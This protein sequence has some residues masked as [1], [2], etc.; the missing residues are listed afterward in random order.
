MKKYIKRFLPIVLAVSIMLCSMVLCANVVEFSSM[1]T[2]VASA[3]EYEADG[4]AYTD[5]RNGTCYINGFS[6]EEAATGVSELVIPETLNG[7]TV[8]GIQLGAFM[9]CTELKKVVIP[10]T[11]KVISHYVFR[12]C[13]NL[14]EIVLSKNLVSIGYDAFKSCEKLYNIEIPDSVTEISW[15]VF[16]NTAYYNDETNWEN[17]LLYLDN[18]L[19]SAKSDFSGELIIEDGTTVMAD[20]V[21]QKNSKITKVTIPGSLTV[22]SEQAFEYCSGIK[23]VVLSEGV[24]EIGANVFY[25]SP[26]LYKITL[27]STLKKIGHN[28]FGSSGIKEPHFNGTIDQWVSI[29]FVSGY[30]NPVCEAEALYINGEPVKEV[31]I[32][33]PVIKAGAFERLKTLEK[34]TLTDSV[35]EIEDKAFYYNTNLKEIHFGKNIKKVGRSV[36]ENCSKIETFSTTASVN[37]WAQIDFY[38][39]QSNPFTITNNW[40]IEGELL[41]NATFSGITEIKPYAFYN[42]DSLKSIKISTPV[43]TIGKGAFSNCS[44]LSYIE[45]ADSVKTSG[46]G[47]FA[48]STNISYVNFLGTPEQWINIDFEGGANPIAYA[49]SLYINGELLEEVNF[50]NVTEIKPYTFSNCASI[51]AVTIPD[52]VEKIGAYAFSGTSISSINIPGSVKTIDVYA[53]SNT[54]IEN[55]V[56]QDGTTT[57]GGS[58]FKDCV[59]LKSV[60]IPD[61]V[62]EIQAYV[63]KGCSALESVDLP[64]TVTRFNREEFYG[65]TSLK[66]VNYRGT[67]D[68]WAS[69]VF[70]SETSNPVYYSRCLYLNDVLLENAVIKE[71]KRV[72]D[73]TFIRCD[74]IK[75]LVVG[76]NTESINGAFVECQGLTSV[77]IQESIKW[78]SVNSFERCTALVE[79]NISEDGNPINLSSG[80]F[81][82]CTALEEIRLPKRVTKIGNQTFYGCTSL[83]VVYISEEVERVGYDAFYKCPSLEIVYYESDELA[84]A[85]INIGYGNEALL[86]AQTHYNVHDIESHYTTITVHATCTEDGSITKSCPCGYSSFTIIHAASHKPVLVNQHDATCTTDGYSGDTICEACEEV[87]EQGNIIKAYGHTGGVATC[88]KQALCENCNQYYGEFVPHL[89]ANETDEICDE[90]EYVRELNVPQDSIQNNDNNVQDD[91]QDS[92]QNNTNENI[93]NN[94]QNNTQNNVQNNVESNTQVNTENNPQDTTQQS[95]QNNTNKPVQDQNTE[96][97]HF[98]IAGLVLG[99]TLISV[100]IISGAYTT[101]KRK[102]H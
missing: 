47:A 19:V 52:T 35:V 94:A 77:E 101:K 11:V 5:Y 86:S 76:G 43:E 82:Q 99:L 8:T 87:F 30:T 6:S 49:K 41:E 96:K 81:Y 2:T 59:N 97:S 46:E 17:G 92:E 20:R 88:S 9:D 42:C 48:N 7:I 65:C 50:E 58:A 64:N 33:A 53:F 34:V 37:E 71:A 80:A 102:N 29:E 10:D 51:K 3:A 45:I 24:E 27:P 61:S 69:I 36:F 93:Q 89:Y 23:E 22:I 78:I 4:F 66:K 31:V 54:L 13:T 75:T 72:N 98:V 25:Y 57:I 32:S 83:K 63:F 56:I 91:M 90:C 68:Q 70:Y 16:D 18:C 73:N 21:F 38:N 14:E 79:I 15:E 62:T 84:Y 100:S 95:A 26:S 67:I 1:F 28:A 40:Y 85:E 12:G 55:L 60:Y 44:N 74:S 39:E